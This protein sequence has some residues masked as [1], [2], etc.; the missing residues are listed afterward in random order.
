M[1]MEK[2]ANLLNEWIDKGHDFSEE[3]I[4][5]FCLTYANSYDE[6][7]GLWYTVCGCIEEE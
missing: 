3:S 4:N 6:Y 7:M 2:I 5:Q 1:D